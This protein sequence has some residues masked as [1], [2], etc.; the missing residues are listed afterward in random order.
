[1]GRHRVLAA[2]A[3]TLEPRATHTEIQRCDRRDRWRTKEEAPA[4][5]QIPQ[6]PRQ[7]DSIESGE[8]QRRRLQLGGLLS[9]G[10]ESR[11]TTLGV[12]ITAPVALR[13]RRLPTGRVAH[14]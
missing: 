12:S 13:R 4:E 11:S 5:I 8:A 10:V 6:R 9:T 14:W 1:M 7:D 2:V 3:D